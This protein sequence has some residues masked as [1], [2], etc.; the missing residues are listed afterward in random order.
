MFVVRRDVL[1]PSFES[2]SRQLKLISY[3]H[4]AFHFPFDGRKRLGMRVKSNEINT[5]ELTGG[6]VGVAI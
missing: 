4:L 6:Q 5:G 3:L 1:V 2:Q